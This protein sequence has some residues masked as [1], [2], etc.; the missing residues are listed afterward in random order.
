V[1]EGSL[2]VDGN[3]EGSVAGVLLASGMSR[4]FAGGNKLLAEIDGEPMVRRVAAAYLQGGLSP[5]LVVV[6]YGS[7]EVSQA[8]AD[9]PVELVHN[10][11]YREGQSRALIAGVQSLPS[12]TRAAVIGVADQPLL[13][14]SVISGIVELYRS[15]NAP[16]VVPRYAGQRGNPALFDRSLFSELLQVKGDEGG[17]FVLRRHADRIAWL[18]VDLDAVGADVDT[19]EDLESAR[20]AAAHRSFTEG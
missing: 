2:L 15:T 8:L 3:A 6:G 1:S 11:A 12:H 20:A 4:R 13:V 19:L 14:S 7:D 17:R 5:V 16:L 10:S 9:S 18:D